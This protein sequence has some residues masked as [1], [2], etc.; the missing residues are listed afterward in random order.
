MKTFGRLRVGGGIALLVLLLVLLSI[1]LSLFAESPKKLLA[2]KTAAWDFSIIVTSGGSPLVHDF[3]RCGVTSAAKV[4]LPANAAQV[5]RDPLVCVDGFALLDT[6]AAPASAETVVTFNDGAN[7]ASF[8]L[9]ALGVLPFD[10]AFK[11][12]RPVVS[13]DYEGTWITVVPTYDRTPI[14]VV[15]WNALDH[16]APPI[17]ETFKASPPIGQHRITAKGTFWAEVSIGTDP[18]YRCFPSKSCD[19]YGAVYGFVS[20]GTPIGGSLRVSAFGE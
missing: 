4:S 5:L 11:V 16:S 14:F 19:V 12:R 6:P 20:S 10:A 18:T 15:L 7:A 8:T 9:P 17:V 13:D 3:S 1:S 2:A